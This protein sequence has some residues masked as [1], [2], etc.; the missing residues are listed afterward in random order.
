MVKNLNAAHADYEIVYVPLRSRIEL[1][2]SVN[3]KSE[4]AMQGMRATQ[5]L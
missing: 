3:E 2:V 1:R 5:L 4:K